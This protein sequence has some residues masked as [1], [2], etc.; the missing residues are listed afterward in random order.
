[1]NCKGE[2]FYNKATRT[3][4][5]A[6]HTNCCFAKVPVM[7]RLLQATH[8]D[9]KF[10]LLCFAA[11]TMTHFRADGSILDR[12]ARRTSRWVGG[13]GVTRRTRYEGAKR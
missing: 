10:Y 5:F 11:S 9:G 7:W 3:P 6:G 8:A 1:M 2:M 12:R 4:P 13:L